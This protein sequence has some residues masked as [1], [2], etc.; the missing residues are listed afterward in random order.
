MQ[1]LDLL[2]CPTNPRL[3]PV[4]Q[5]FGLVKLG[6]GEHEPQLAASEIAFD[7]VD[8]VNS[9]LGGAVRMPSVE[10]RVAVIVEIHRDRDPKEAADRGHAV[11]VRERR[12]RIV[13]A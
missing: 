6:P 9:D 8:L 10:M 13:G 2:E 7:H 12:G 3:M 4:L 1:R 5:Q 11:D